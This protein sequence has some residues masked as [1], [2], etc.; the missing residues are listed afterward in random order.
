MST[1]ARWWMLTLNNPVTETIE[2]LYKQLC[3]DFG[4]GQVEIGESGTLHIQ[5]VFWFKN[6]KRFGALKA[7]VPGGHWEAVKNVESSLKYVVKEATRHEGPWTFGEKPV[8]RNDKADWDEVW[9]LAK[10]GK[11]EEIP[12]EIRIQHYSNL[13]K[14]QKDFMKTDFQTE[15]TR[16]VWIHGLPGCGKTHLIR[17]HFKDLY[18]KNNNK[19]WDGYQ[20]QEYVVLE[21][22]D[23]SHWQFLVNN[24]KIWADKYSFIGES[25]GG[26]V[27][28]VY[29]RLFVT[30][31][32]TISKLFD[33][34]EKEEKKVDREL[35]SAVS[36]R[37][38]EW[39]MTK[40]IDGT[41]LLDNGDITLT[42]DEWVARYR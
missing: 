38:E 1:K 11:I 18:L 37:F 4:T 31:N 12:A 20:T 2:S 26:Q 24:M 40:S 7:A 8:K 42:V 6:Q 16:G 36:R 5:A 23:N 10:S 19:W 35:R 15:S 39:E 21:D 22:V 30:S 29:R 32:Y 34:L 25:K 13:K 17:E 27:A 41:R 3:A 9:N 28:P 14:I 33:G